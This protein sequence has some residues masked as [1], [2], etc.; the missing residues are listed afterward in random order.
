MD[1]EPLDGH[2]MKIALDLV[3]KLYPLKHM[4]VD[5]ILPSRYFVCL[6]LCKNTK[7]RI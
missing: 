2:E 7:F 4:D 3:K 5:G 1:N 6:K